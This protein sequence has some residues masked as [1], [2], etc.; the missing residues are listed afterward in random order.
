M[1]EGRKTHYQVKH[2][3]CVRNLAKLSLILAYMMG[4]ES[5]G[6]REAQRSN[7]V[8]ILGGGKMAESICARAL[9]AL[10]TSFSR[11][12][13]SSVVNSRAVGSIASGPKFLAT[14]TN[15]SCKSPR[16]S[17]KSASDSLAAIRI[18]KLDI[19]RNLW[20]V[21]VA[22]TIERLESTKR[23]SSEYFV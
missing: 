3:V 5:S 17:A 23:A 19:C 1:G 16:T 7:A 13:P 14:T 9:H 6:H 2:F 15:A 8:T 21:Q 11:A 12:H 20:G 18:A 22:R 10:R 4:L